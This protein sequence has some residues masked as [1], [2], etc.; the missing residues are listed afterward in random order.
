M[1]QSHMP[2]NSKWSCKTAWNG[3]VTTG[4]SAR[5]WS[6]GLNCRCSDLRSNKCFVVFCNFSN[7][8]FEQKTI[9]IISWVIWWIW[10]LMFD[11]KLL[12]DDAL[13]ANNKLIGTKFSAQKLERKIGA[14]VRLYD[15][16]ISKHK[17]WNAFTT[18]LLAKEGVSKQLDNE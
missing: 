17:N 7:L 13:C 14:L 4:N 12:R 6:Q 16:G 18:D 3:E 15:L 11:A 2:F 10:S 1:C 9:Y 8:P 5:T